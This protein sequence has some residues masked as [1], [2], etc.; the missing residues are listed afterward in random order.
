[1]PA[2]WRRPELDR[3][4]DP[5]ADD[6]WKYRTTILGEEQHISRLTVGRPVYYPQGRV[7]YT[8]VMIEGYLSKIT[9]VFGQGPVDSLINAITFVKKFHDDIFEM[10]PGVK[11]RVRPLKGSGRKTAKKKAREGAPKR[12]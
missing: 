4:D 9:P 5:I 3:I 2:K 10:V 7:W 1:M 8:P 11:P 12:R 6:Y